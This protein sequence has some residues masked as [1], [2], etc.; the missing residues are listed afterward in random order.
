[1][2]IRSAWKL[3]HFLMYVSLQVHYKYICIYDCDCV[4]LLGGPFLNLAGGPEILVTP[5][6]VLYIYLG[7][8]K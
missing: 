4:S 7:F 8:T 1:M 2:R 3:M 6:I 5:L